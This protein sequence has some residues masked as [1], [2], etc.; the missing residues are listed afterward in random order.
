MVPRS[1]PALLE[2]KYEDVSFYMAPKSKT[3][4]YRKRLHSFVK[5]HCSRRRPLSVDGENVSRL[6]LK[7][8]CIDDS[9]VILNLTAKVLRRSGCLVDTAENGHLALD[10][11]H[12]HKLDYYDMILTDIEMPVMN[13]IEF[14]KCFRE[15]EKTSNTTNGSTHRMPIFCISSA[16]EDELRRSALNEGADFL[17]E[18]PLQPKCDILLQMVAPLREANQPIGTSDRTR[19]NREC[20][21]PKDGQ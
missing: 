17:L 7:I 5:K 18:K 20:S 12:R 2:Y 1:M 21:V 10:L 4:M 14:I 3:D 8:L 11:I 19:S 16:I 15:H 13:G 6:P 9:K